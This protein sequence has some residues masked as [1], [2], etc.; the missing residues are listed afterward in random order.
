LYNKMEEIL[1]ILSVLHSN[2]RKII[3]LKLEI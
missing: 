3:P 1:F 2:W